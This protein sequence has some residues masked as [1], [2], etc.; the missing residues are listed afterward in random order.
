[1]Y[2]PGGASSGLGGARTVTCFS[3]SERTSR[4][5]HRWSTLNECVTEEGRTRATSVI[6]VGEL[7]PM[8]KGAPYVRLV[9]E[10]SMEGRS[11]PTQYPGVYSSIRSSSTPQDGF[12]PPVQTRPSGN[13]TA[14]E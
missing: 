7:I 4:P 1:M 2:H 9:G 5:T 3:S 10:S 14:T 6:G 13:R 8:S 11:S 12:P